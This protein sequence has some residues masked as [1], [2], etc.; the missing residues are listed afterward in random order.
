VPYAKTF[1]YDTAAT[2]AKPGAT[3]RATG[4]P[5]GLSLNA[6]TGRISGT[7][8]AE[9][10][11][12]V[13]VEAD[14]GLL[15]PVS[16]GYTVRTDL[17]APVV[18]DDV[19]SAWHEHAVAVTLTATDGGS[20]VDH[21]VY[22]IDD[23]PEATYDPAHKPALGDGQRLHYY[24][25]DAAGNASAPAVSAAAKVDGT[26]P[27]APVLTLQTAAALAFTAEADATL[28]C[29]FDGAPLAP[30]G[31]SVSLA[32]LA[33]G[34]HT[35]T[36]VAHDAA[37]HASQPLVV[38]FTV[39]APAAPPVVIVPE[40]TA[41]LTGRE[42][43]KLLKT[44]SGIL[45]VRCGQAP[46]RVTATGTVTAR[47]RK[48]GKLTIKPVALTSRADGKLVLGASKAVRKAAKR[49]GARV[50]LRVTFTSGGRSQTITIAA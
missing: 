40:P 18:A 21:I 44:G 48:L 31:N 37:G 46:C 50:S 9:G 35:F 33:P 27:A 41:L 19:D 2:A 12:N 49:G 26:P 24:A 42:A 38:T 17:T 43:R 45:V 39:A 10:T 30:C 29:A 22:S 8:T 16:R 15:A 32:G 20:G 11:F 5:A 14:T 36:A 13:T 6:A 47:G 25:V 1:A 7:A 34:A 28:T 23:G 4:L 3:Y